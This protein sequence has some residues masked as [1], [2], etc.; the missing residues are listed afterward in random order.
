MKEPVFTYENGHAICCT[1]DKFGRT[2]KGEGLVF[3]RR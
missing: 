3:S 2:I 1:E